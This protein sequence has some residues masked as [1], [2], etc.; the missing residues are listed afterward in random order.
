MINNLVAIR[1]A[2]AVYTKKYA[3][4][5]ITEKDHQRLT[6]LAEILLQ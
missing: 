4:T 1:K 2:A 3:K 5:L 6:Q